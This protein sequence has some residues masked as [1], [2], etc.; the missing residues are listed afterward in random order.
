MQ[1]SPHEQFLEWT[2]RRRLRGMHFVQGCVTLPLQL[3]LVV[4]VLILV[5]LIP[6]MIAD[7]VVLPL[8]ISVLCVLFFISMFVL[9]LRPNKMPSRTLRIDWQSIVMTETTI[10]GTKKRKMDTSGAICSA[11]HLNL[12]ERLFTFDLFRVDSA[13]HIEI[14]R[15]NETFLFPCNDEREQSQIIKHIKEFLSQ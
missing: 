11:V 10:F 3:L 2:F 15:N 5:S 4:P 1:P 13:Y 7:W 8:A 9:L 6:D 12:F 14:T